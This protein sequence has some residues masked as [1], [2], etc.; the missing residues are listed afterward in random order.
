MNT[1][2]LWIWQGNIGCSVICILKIHGLL[3]VLSYAKVLNLPRVQICYTDK[4]FW[5]KHF[6]V[7]IWQSSE[8]TT[9]LKYVKFLD[10][11]GFWICRGSLRK[12]SI[13][14]TWQD[15]EFSSGS[16]FCRV[17][18]MPGLQKALN[19]TFYYRYLIELWIRL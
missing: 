15:S 13:I 1:Q 8:Y 18:N 2:R 11:L 6:I 17:L 5:I 12:S 7:Y 10:I 9:V 14:Y 4:G 3:N 19:K 16:E